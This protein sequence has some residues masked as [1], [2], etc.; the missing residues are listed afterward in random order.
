MANTRA[1]VFGLRPKPPSTTA[2]PTSPWWSASAWP[3]SWRTCRSFF[4]ARSTHTAKSATGARRACTR[5]PKPRCPW[6]STANRSGRY[7][8]K[9]KRSRK[10]SAS[11]SGRSDKP[12]AK[13]DIGSARL[14]RELIPGRW[15]AEQAMTEL[16]SKG[17]DLTQL[18]YDLA[19]NKAPRFFASGYGAGSF[20]GELVAFPRE[21]AI[22]W[23]SAVNRSEEHT[24]EL[25]S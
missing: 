15:T 3:R 22:R 20:A 1:V 2:S 12:G 5:K 6:K 8:W 23:N 4:R 21:G 24:S 9:S 7:R 25:Q 18:D 11:F 14:L 13:T 17:G 10:P 19:T 16:S